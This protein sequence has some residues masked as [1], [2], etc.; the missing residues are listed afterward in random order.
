MH[1]GPL[2]VAICFMPV[3]D[4]WCSLTLGM[5]VSNQRPSS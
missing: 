5:F 2:V 4:W 1:L 3:L